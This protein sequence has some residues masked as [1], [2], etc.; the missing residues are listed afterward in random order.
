MR[1]IRNDGD[2]YRLFLLEITIRWATVPHG[3]IYRLA[4]V[5]ANILMTSAYFLQKVFRLSS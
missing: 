1:I 2:T 5:G 4:E 3:G